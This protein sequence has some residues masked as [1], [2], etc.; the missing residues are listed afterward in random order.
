MKYIHILIFLITHDLTELKEFWKDEII[1]DK[2]FKWRRLFRKLRMQNNDSYLQYQNKNFI[3]LFRLTHF[4]YRH[5]NKKQKIVAKHLQLK[6]IKDFGVEI[7]F[8]AKIGKRFSV[9]HFSGIVISCNAVI[10]DNVHVMQNVI[11]GMKTI[12]AFDGNFYLPNRSII[13]GNNVKIG[14]H[15]I[16]LSDNLVV[17]DNVKIGAMS[18]INKDIIDNCTVFTK[19]NEI[20]IRN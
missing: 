1:K 18:F 14:A 2:P 4:M 7:E 15:S 16:I 12:A 19:K 5:G 13:I 9:G 11:I 6:L 20:I 8:G 10:G 17:G 3:F